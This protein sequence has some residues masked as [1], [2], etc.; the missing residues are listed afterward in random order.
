MSSPRS[1]HSSAFKMHFK[2]FSLSFVS[3]LRLCT[4]IP[5][6]RLLKDELCR[7]ISVIFIGMNFKVVQISYDIFIS[8]RI[9]SRLCSLHFILDILV[10]IIY[11]DNNNIAPILSANYSL[12]RVETFLIVYCLSEL[13]LTVKHCH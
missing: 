1:F 3:Y 5:S 2:Q 8:V 13:T 4:V 10:D 7:A 12:L 6:K 11:C 9:C